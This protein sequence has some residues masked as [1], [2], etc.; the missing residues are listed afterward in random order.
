MATGG[1]GAGLVS[2]S[3]QAIAGAVG[4]ASPPARFARLE[5][6]LAWATEIPA[7]ALVTVEILVLLI[8]V[9]SRYVFDS[10]LTWT[11]ELASALFLWLAMLGS[12]IA[13]RRAEHMRL[14][15]LIGLAPL[16]W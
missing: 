14:A 2:A 12:V 1:D 13:L 3:E 10:P 6:A 5:R 15:F 7:A 16:R 8:G 4:R 9:V 11:D